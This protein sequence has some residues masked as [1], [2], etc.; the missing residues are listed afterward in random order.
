[1]NQYKPHEHSLFQQSTARCTGKK[2]MSSPPALNE[3]GQ[4]SL[5]L[6]SYQAQ[7]P[8]GILGNCYQELEHTRITKGAEC[9]WVQGFEII[10]GTLLK[11][12]LSQTELII[13][14]QLALPMTAEYFLQKVLIPETAL[15]LILE[16]LS[17]PMSDPFVSRQLK[18][19]FIS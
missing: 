16:D 15:G 18:L 8:I 9:L 3:A 19:R 13:T 1:M 11:M 12:F 14:T 6:T 17:S 2:L 10:Y 5:I 4:W 7:K